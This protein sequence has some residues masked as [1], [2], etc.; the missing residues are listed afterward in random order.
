MPRG[1]PAGRS[2]EECA[3]PA[4]SERRVV[5][6]YIKPSHKHQ[7]DWSRYMGASHVTVWRAMSDLYPYKVSHRQK[8]AP[9]DPDR[10]L[11]D[12][13]NVADPGEDIFV[14]NILFTDECTFSNDGSTNRHNAHHW[15][16][17]GNNPH[18][19]QDNRGQGDFSVSVWAGI[20]DDFVSG[21]YVWP[22]NVTAQEYADFLNHELPHLLENLPL[23]VRRDMWFQQDGHPAHTSLAARGILNRDFPN[24][25]LISQFDITLTQHRAN[26]AASTLVTPDMLRNVRQDFVKRIQLCF[27]NESGLIEHG[28]GPDH[29]PHAVG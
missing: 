8:L 9:G 7:S 14:R 23:E 5:E 16:D 17:K 26:L 13:E 15:S 28:G 3:K 25:Y 22:N 19:Y 1:A 4:V 18:C 24:R 20:V 2:P 12:I 27:E 21:P 10:R 11:W 29:V 6:R